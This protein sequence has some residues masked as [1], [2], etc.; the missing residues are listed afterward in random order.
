MTDILLKAKTAVSQDERKALYRQQQELSLE[1]MPIIPL[2]NS[3][4]LTAHSE[5]LQG[6]RPMRTG[7]LKTLKD[8]WFAA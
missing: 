6:F 4:I 3:F 7:F 2:V 1:Q 8:S 5:K